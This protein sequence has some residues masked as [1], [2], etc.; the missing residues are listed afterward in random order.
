MPPEAN[1][2]RASNARP[3]LAKANHKELAI[4]LR[5]Y[6]KLFPVAIL[7][8]IA[9]ALSAL[10]GEAQQKQTPTPTRAKI[11]PA[12]PVMVRATRFAVSKPLRDMPANREIDPS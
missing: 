2:V 10:P 7:A 1:C 11:Q 5:K 4:M 12:K 8:F 3:W 6:K 9:V